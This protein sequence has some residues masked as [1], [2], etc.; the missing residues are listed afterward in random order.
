MGTH[1]PLALVNWTRRTLFISNRRDSLPLLRSPASPVEACCLLFA[2][3]ARLT[4]SVI[5]TVG[6][7]LWVKVATLQPPTPLLKLPR[8]S[9]RD[10]GCTV[11][12]AGLKT[13]C[14]LAVLELQQPQQASCQLPTGLL[15]GVW[16][17]VGV[18]FAEVINHMGQSDSQSR[19]WCRCNPPPALWL[20]TAAQ[21][22]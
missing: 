16:H 21:R 17:N 2:W 5:Q 14:R 10:D 20:P 7:S 12:I 11:H 8:F 9:L 15:Q 22:L 1:P 19:L 13:T 4:V 3:L 6:Y 18:L